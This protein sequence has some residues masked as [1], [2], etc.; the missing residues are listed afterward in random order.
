M[1]DAKYIGVDVHQGTISLTRSR[2][3][4]GIRA[5]IW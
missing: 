1:N 3:P 5:G 4:F 2:W